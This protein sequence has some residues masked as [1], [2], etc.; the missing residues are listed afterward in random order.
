MA[1]QRLPDRI[2]SRR[3]AVALATGVA[4]CAGS[5]LVTGFSP[6]WVVVAVAA[7]LFFLTPD[8]LVA[9]GI[10]TLGDFGQPL[11][12]VGAG[13]TTVLLFAGITFVTLRISHSLGRDHAETVFAV[14]AVQTVAA[15]ALTVTPLS[16]L[17]VGI[18]SG[19]TLGLAGRGMTDGSVVPR[20]RFL[21]SVGLAAGTLGIAGIVGGRRLISS[22]SESEDDTPADPTAQAILDAAADRDL[23]LREFEGL[24]STDFY[25][26]DINTAN[27]RIDPEEW[28]LTITGAVDEE[29]TYDYEDITARPAEYRFE[30]LR[31]V[32]EQLN[33]HKMDTAL[34]TAT[35]IPP[36]LEEAGV[37][38]EDECCVMLRAADDY[39]EEFPLSALEE[40]TLAYGMNGK[41]LPRA[42][43]APVRA[44]VPGHWGEI[45]VKWIDEIEILEREA[46][47][48]WEEKGWH[49]TGPANTVAKLHTV[50]TAG[51][52]VVI[53]GHAYAG[54]RGISAVEVST[55]GGETWAEA[56]LSAPLP[57]PVPTDTDPSAVE[58]SGQARDAW[59]TW[60]YEYQ[61]EREHEVVVRAVEADGTIQPREES[62]P[63]PSG[64]TGWVSRTISP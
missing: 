50:T 46:D 14:A 42:H 24:V 23:G 40:A 7:T 56:E 16:A 51:S 37:S 32:G 30:T 2:R 21:R 60:R 54:L 5:F 43:G 55:D 18:A 64:A 41:P 8:I 26:V 6:R 44:L 28:S 35:P 38:L 27:P 19:V 3:T 63:F 39:Y 57:A 4:A 53:G 13:M 11:L 17:G 47:G 45:N 52:R 9:E 29:V 62:D 58:L 22:G 33:G 1:M 25:E 15:F 34:W 36:L 20:R 61:S 59:R 10:Q 48:Y 12:L 31:C 49:G